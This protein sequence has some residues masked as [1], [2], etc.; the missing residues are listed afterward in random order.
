M[1]K[2]TNYV[3][4]T[5]CLAICEARNLKAVE[6]A[7][8]YKVSGAKGRN[9][10]IAKTKQVGRIDISGFL[11]DGPGVTNLS[12]G[13][14]FGAVGQQ[15]DF[16]RTPE[17]TLTTLGAVLDHMLT[18]DARVIEKKSVAPKAA[19]QAPETDETKKARRA[20]IA[21]VAREKNV[22]VSPALND[23]APLLPAA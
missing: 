12:E 15:L 4:S 5:A 13:E 22:E 11:F 16:S 10:Y 6:Q 18:L 2:N 20:L 9:V 1:K 23:E 3:Q 21:K 7:G 19:P 14:K 17:E 8:F